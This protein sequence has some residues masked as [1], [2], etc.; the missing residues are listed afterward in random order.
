MH[1]E[2]HDRQRE[3][4]EVFWRHAQDAELRALILSPI[5]VNRANLN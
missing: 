2:L 3:N 5:T 4:V 1:P